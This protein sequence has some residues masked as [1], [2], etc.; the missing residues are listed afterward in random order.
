MEIGESNIITVRAHK[1]WNIAGI[2][3]KAGETYE[4]HA[5]GCWVDWVSTHGPGGDPSTSFYMRLFER[6]RRI[7]TA[8]WFALVGALNSDLKTAFVIGQ[9]GVKKMEDSGE[10]AC[11]ANDVRGFYWNNWGKVQ[12]T[13]RRLQ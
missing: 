1:K 8:N 10:L 11:F 13:V 2:V 7:R 9:G 3:L 4:F 5:E 6:W 12:L